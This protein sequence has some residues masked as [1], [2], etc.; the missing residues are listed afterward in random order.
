MSRW[1]TTVST[2]CGDEA[3][4]ELLGRGDRAV[5]AAGAADR[6]GHI[7]LALTAVSGRDELEQLGVAVEEL[8]GAGLV[9]DVRRHLLVQAGV[10]A[11]L[12]D[13]VR[14][15]QEP[16]VHDQ[17]GVDRQAVLEAEGHDGGPQ[18]GLLLA[19]ELG[20][21]LGAQLVHVQAGGVDH[22]VG[23]AAQLAQQF[24]LGVDAVDDAAVA[25]EGVRAAHRLE[26]AH[27]GVVRGLQEDDPPGD[28]AWTPGRRGTR[29]GC[30]R[31]GG[32]VRRRRPRSAPR[33]PG[34]GRRAPPWWGSARAAGCRRRTSRGPPDTWRPSTGPAPDIPEMI[35]SSGMAASGHRRPS[36]SLRTLLCR[37]RRLPAPA[38]RRLLLV[39]PIRRRCCGA[40]A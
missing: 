30:R 7:A 32:R 37:C 6:D 33:C 14:V 4:G 36:P 5:L 23:V 27:Q 16:H 11:Q 31:S 15:G 29:G 34:S 20:V 19:R 8:L 18:L 12:R 10:R 25:L 3:G 1:T 39:R 40:S 24:A 21:H 17:V 35:T 9:E 38:V 28:A 2:P 22:Q 13:P 26:A